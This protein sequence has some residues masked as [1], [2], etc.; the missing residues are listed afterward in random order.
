MAS[1]G[2][3]TDGSPKRLLQAT[4][5][6]QRHLMC[7]VSDQTC[8]EDAMVR[9]EQGSGCGQEGMSRYHRRC[10][11]DVHEAIHHLVPAK[12]RAAAEH[13]DLERMRDR[14]ATQPSFNLLYPAYLY[15]RYTLPN[16]ELK[17]PLS[18]TDCLRKPRMHT[19]SKP[20]L[21]ARLLNPSHERLAGEAAKNYTQSHKY[22]VSGDLA[23]A[24][25][26]RLHPL[27]F[28]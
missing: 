18:P 22:T 8:F 25:P 9:S 13:H 23:G 28:W 19:T 21:K 7:A 17:H 11:R 12:R 1:R 10:G 3:S 16:N 6:A 24:R 2:A 4:R 26:F 14:H 20:V 15:Q 5:R 27:L